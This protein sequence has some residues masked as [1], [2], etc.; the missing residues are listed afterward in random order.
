LKLLKVKGIGGS[1]AEVHK[2]F[3]MEAQVMNPSFEWPWNFADRSRG[4]LRFPL[5]SLGSAR[6]RAR[7]ATSTSM[8]PHLRFIDG[9]HVALGRTLK[10]DGPNLVLLLTPGDLPQR[11]RER[12][13]NEA[14]PV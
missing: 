13:L 2:Q 4:W 8:R 5:E 14:V 9:F 3:A 1:H 7:E 11:S 6:S 12:V 10:W